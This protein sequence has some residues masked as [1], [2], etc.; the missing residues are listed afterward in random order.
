MI[1][2]LFFISVANADIKISQLPLGNAT[3][4]SVNDSVPYVDSSAGVTKRFKLGDLSSIPFF[5]IGPKYSAR[6]SDSGTTCSIVSQ[7]P[8]SWISSVNHTAAG[9]CQVSFVG[10]TFSSIPACS[11]TAEQPSVVAIAQITNDSVLST[12][13]LHTGLFNT[14]GVGVSGSRTLI[15]F[16]QP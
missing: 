12:S 1:L 15:C 11:V 9:K 16:P 14:V 3:T 10:G 5:S 4:S 13:N 8:P 6:L 2:L 7:N